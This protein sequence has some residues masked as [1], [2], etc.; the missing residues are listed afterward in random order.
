[1]A[2]SGNSGNHYQVLKTSRVFATGA[3]AATATDTATATGSEIAT[4]TAT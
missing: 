4:A 1:V 2:P 3:T